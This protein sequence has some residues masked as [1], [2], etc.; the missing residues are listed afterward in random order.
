[1]APKK[2][3]LLYQFKVTLRDIHPPIWRRIQVWEDTTLAQLHRILQIVM[4]W[5]DYHLHEFVIERR[6]YSVPDPDDDFYERKV[7]DERR[8]RL[9]HVVPRV[10]TA[11]EYLYDFGDSWLHDLL[12]EAI[13]VLD[14]TQQY[15]IC[16]AGERR[17]PPEDVGGTSG[18]EEYLEVIADP[19]HEEHEN[20]LRW[21]GPFDPEAFSIDDVNQR[22]QKKFRS[23][24]KAAVTPIAASPHNGADHGPDKADL[25][26]AFLT[27]PGLLP[28]YQKRIRP[29]EKVPLEL[30]ARQCELILRH[31]FAE[32]ELTQRLRIVTE[33]GKSPIYTFTLDELDELS[34]YVAAEANHAKDKKLQKEL[35]Q[36]Y[37]HIAD[38]LESY[39]DQDDE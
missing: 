23:L 33:P 7:I 22:L 4:N 10:G 37:A 15:P 19:E 9:Q 20:M 12:L 34:G 13:L 32:D 8:Q 17:T 6:V 27:A 25:V 1:M 24:R 39:T 26:S 21:R 14:A 28:R 16:I 29:D 35:Q 2:N 11:F 5:D 38:V 18:Y 3:R 31:T 36:L 30:N